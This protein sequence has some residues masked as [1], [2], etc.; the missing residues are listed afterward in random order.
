MPPSFQERF[1]NIT[2][3]PRL[4][5]RRPRP[6]QGCVS[7]LLLSRTHSHFLALI[8]PFLADHYGPAE[9]VFV[10]GSTCGQTPLPMFLGSD[11][12]AIPTG[13]IPGATPAPH[14]PRWH[15]VVRIQTR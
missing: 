2:I 4:N 8:L 1:S 6:T 9:I 10:S 14:C 3:L 15:Q 5:R 7:S 13:A 12:H 11:A